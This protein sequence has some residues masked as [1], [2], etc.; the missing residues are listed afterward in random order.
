MKIVSTHV[1]F[2]LISHSIFLSQKQNLRI[3][4]FPRFFFI[5]SGNEFI[6]EHYS[7]ELAQKK[8]LEQSSA[9]KK[10]SLQ[11]IKTNLHKIPHFLLISSLKNPTAIHK[12]PISAYLPYK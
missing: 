8:A 5:S 3:K 7:P 2:S 1:R 6:F 12:F 4:T 11:G 9:G 10:Q